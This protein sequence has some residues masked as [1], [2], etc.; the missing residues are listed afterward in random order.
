MPVFYYLNKDEAA[1][2]Y[3]YLKLYPPERT[4]PEPLMA[5]TEQKRGDGKIVP[6]GFHIAPASIIPPSEGR[7]L[8]V[9][10]FPIFAG[11]LLAGGS[12]F[13]LWEIRRLTALS[14]SRSVFVIGHLGIAEHLPT[15]VSSTSRPSGWLSP[16]HSASTDTTQVANLDESAFHDDDFYTFERSWLERWLERKDEAA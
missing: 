12:W 1:D 15:P 16:T 13:T 4:A 14:P 11:L 2:A 6:V 9:I 7:D 10:A 3:L 5:A 8:F